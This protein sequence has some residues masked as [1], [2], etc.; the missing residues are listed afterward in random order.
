MRKTFFIIF[1][2]FA[3]INADAQK[4][5]EKKNLQ[6]RID[7][8]KNSID[9]VK[10][11]LVDTLKVQILDYQQLTD[12][13]SKEAEEFSIENNNLRKEL[14]KFL[15]L[16]SSDTLI[17]HQDFKTISDVPICLQERTD[18]VKSIIELRKRIV[19]A[20][21]TA[22]ELEQKLGNSPIAYAAIREKIEKDL[23]EIQALIHKIKSMNLSSLSDEQQKYFRP[24]LTNRYNSF[25]KYY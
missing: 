8:R 12:F 5:S 14:H 18:I 23:V 6:E 24:G 22:Q 9:K 7:Y 4:V 13:L 25:Q 1:A 15:L 20:E 16:T 17:F 2:F 11:G 3:I 21:S 10:K 19:T